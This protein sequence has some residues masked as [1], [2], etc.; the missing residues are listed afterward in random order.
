[1]IACAGTAVS[2]PALSAHEPGRNENH[3]PSTSLCRKTC[4]EHGRGRVRGKMQV[5]P[6]RS[7]M[8]RSGRDDKGE[9]VFVSVEVANSNRYAHLT[10][11]KPRNVISG[12]W[13]AA[14]DYAVS[15]TSGAGEASEEVGFLSA[16]GEAGAS[17][18]ARNYCL[19][20]W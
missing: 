14:P 16:A 6:L 15:A 12:H 4:A 17:C 19:R 5:P 7:A 20:S 18:I 10:M 9:E 11:T 13:S 1:M 8:A 2:Q 3:D